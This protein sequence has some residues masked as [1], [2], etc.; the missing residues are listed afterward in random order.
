MHDANDADSMEDD[1]Y[2]GDT[3]VEYSDD[4]DGDEDDDDD[5]DYEFD[6]DSVDSDDASARRRQQV[7]RGE[8]RNSC[9]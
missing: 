3:A 4:D 8:K 1:Y 6:N 2:S 7:K 9:Y 5:A